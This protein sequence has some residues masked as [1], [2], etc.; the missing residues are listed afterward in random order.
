MLMVLLSLI[1]SV[2]T[3][4]LFHIA[5][6]YICLEVITLTQIMGLNSSSYY[7]VLASV[8]VIKLHVICD[9]LSFIFIYP[10]HVVL[11][12]VESHFK[13]NLCCCFLFP[14]LTNE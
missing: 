5:Y 2:Q 11:I 4:C 12:S 8:S 7:L 3:K 10:I 14:V 6:K 9:Y 1:L 13:N